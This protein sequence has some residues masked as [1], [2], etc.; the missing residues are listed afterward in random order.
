MVGMQE[1]ARF[2]LPCHE[3]VSISC[4]PWSMTFSE[5]CPGLSADPSFEVRTEQSPGAP[6]GDLVTWLEGDLETP[7]YS[8]FIQVNTK[9]EFC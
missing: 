6:P 4:I 1:E 2:S 3:T 5:T 8:D 9:R 7:W